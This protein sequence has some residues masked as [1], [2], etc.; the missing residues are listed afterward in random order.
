MNFKYGKIFLLGF[1]SFGFSLLW[2]IYNAFVSLYL[3]ERFDDLTVCRYRFTI[4]Y[5]RNQ[6]ENPRGPASIG[7]RKSH[8]DDTEDEN[9]VSGL[10]DF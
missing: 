7:V 6:T 2:I 10:N 4:S 9:F 3:E 5:L 1:G 8:R